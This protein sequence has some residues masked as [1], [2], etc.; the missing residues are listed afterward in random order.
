M[1]KNGNIM[2]SIVNYSWLIALIILGCSPELI[3]SDKGRWDLKEI[4]SKVNDETVYFVDYE[5]Q[6]SREFI[7]T[8]KP[9]EVGSINAFFKK[10]KNVPVEFKQ[11]L[12]NGVVSFITKKYLIKQYREKLSNISEEYFQLTN[13]EPDDRDKFTY[14]IDGNVLKP[15]VEPKLATI[16][17]SKIKHIKIIT[18]ELGKELYRVDTNFSIVVIN[19]KK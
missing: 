10:D 18:P 13:K 2:R 19:S 3:K 11:Y 9:E 8:L 4:M 6:P 15:N 12:S 7:F 16:N 17:F 14:I 1:Q 5:K